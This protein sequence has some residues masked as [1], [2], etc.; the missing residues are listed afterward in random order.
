MPEIPRYRGAGS[1]RAQAA[2]PVAA[3]RI[4]PPRQDVQHSIASFF[5]ELRR[6]LGVSPHQAAA[7]LVAHVEVIEAL[8]TG[9]FWAL[10]AWP[11]TAR[12]VMAYTAAAGIDGQPVLNAIA[13]CLR[14]N[15]PAP[16]SAPPGNARRAPMHVSSDR[17]R[18]AGSAIK[19]G[20]RRLPKEALNEARQRP[21]RALYTMALPIAAVILLLNTSLLQSAL[22]HLP[23][24]FVQMLE[25][26]R[27]MMTQYWAPVRDGHRMIE[28]DDPRQRRGDKLQNDKLQNA[29]Q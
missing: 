19:E 16:K 17:L 13:E 15:Q 28:V 4:Q 7:H 22:T 12:I 1:V 10:P 11:E 23:G 14:Q 9:N 2:A 20:A 24:T 21:V 25:G 8:E 18:R 29:G 27:D 6:T 5:R 26:G 3:P